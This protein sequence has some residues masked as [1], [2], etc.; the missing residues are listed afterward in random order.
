MT[1]VAIIGGGITGLTAAFYLKRAGVPVTLFEAA[2]RTGGV[3]RS[4][5]QNGYLIEAG[6]NTILET[7]PLVSELISLL[8]LESRRQYSSP[9]AEARYLVRNGA[10]A[11]LPSSP[12]GFLTSNVFPL[13]A[14]LSLLREPLVPRGRPDKD[15][16]V[17]EFVTRRLG[18]D[19]LDIAV[20]AL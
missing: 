16:S 17:A 20:D 11:A 10:P 18:K 13:R 12:L 7:S 8:Q 1:S 9:E 15:E 19:F 4:A 14:R 2:A 5:R 3:I 6:P